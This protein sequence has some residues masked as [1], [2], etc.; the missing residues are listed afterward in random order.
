MIHQLRMFWNFLFAARGWEPFGDIATGEW[1][2]RRRASGRWE[3]R[4]MTEDELVDALWW[5][6][7]K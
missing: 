5:Q 2:M 3:Y 1:K 6:A 4:D 7:I